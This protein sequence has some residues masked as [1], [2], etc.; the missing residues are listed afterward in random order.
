MN[1]KT[2]RRNGMAKALLLALGILGVSAAWAKQELRLYIW[3]EYIDPEIITDFEK[4]FDCK[5]VQDYYES[6]EEMLAKL[7]AGGVSQYDIVVPSDYIM[8]S[9][10]NLKLLQPLNKSLAP[11]LANLKPRFTTAPFDP[12]NTYSAGYQWGTVGMVYNKKKVKAFTGSWDMIFSDNAAQP[13]LLFDSE[14][15]QIGVALKFLGYSVNTLDKSQ[16]K[17]AADL[18]IKAKKNKACQGFEAN[19]GGRNKVIA[20]AADVALA[21]SGDVFQSMADHPEIGYAIPRE[22]TVVWVDSL[23]IPA[24]A[25]NA[26]MANRFINY[27]LDAKTGA[28]LSNYNHYAT[29]NAASMPSIDPA[30]LKNPAIY[31]DAATEKLLEYV[32]DLGKNNQLY[33]EL[34][35]MIK[36]R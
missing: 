2:R 17:K 29:P 14:R 34:W 26:A 31:P 6:N 22:G 13:F 27:I 30:D 8:T 11:N 24:K 28:R 19:V 21:Y 20:G 32:Q 25:P 10:I 18:L 1:I 35:K 9:L 16:L 15:E 4:Q 3:T 7:Q 5:V 23:C 36:T 12:G 33:S